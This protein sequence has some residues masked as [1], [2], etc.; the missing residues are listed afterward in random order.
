MLIRHPL[1]EMGG[2]VPFSFI[3]CVDLR[4]GLSVL[5]LGPEIYPI[6]SESLD[7]VEL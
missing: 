2:K 7:A 6:F 3:S 1:L 5:P 4:M